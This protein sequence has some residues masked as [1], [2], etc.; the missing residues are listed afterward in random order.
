MTTVAPGLKPAMQRGLIRLG[1]AVVTRWS[2][3]APAGCMNFG[4][5]AL[6]AESA[7]LAANA[8]G[9][10][11][12]GYELYAR[13]A[14]ATD[15][16]DKQALE[17]GCGRGGGAAFLTERFGLARLTGLDFSP[18]VIAVAR[19][20]HVDERLRFVQG[21]AEKLPFAEESFDVVFNVESSHCYPNMGRFAA[22]VFRV[23]RPGG[24][25]LFADLRPAATVAE[26]RESL[27][28]TGLVLLE[29]EN[30]TQNVVR[31]LEL[32]TPR[33]VQFV[34]ENVPR[35]L[36]SQALNFAA[37]TGSEVYRDLS[38][39]KLQYVRYALEKPAS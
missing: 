2:R 19:E 28:G 31:A 27:L 36:Q 25:L 21:D 13:V 6:D 30:I 7:P 32:D 26:M 4:Y 14:G 5:A 34:R 18:R 10:E 3:E 39:G 9:G 22:E 11:T 33:R 8:V 16:K 12:Y 37:T 15:L 29:E 20:R 24:Q 1:Y 17:V 23:L 35:R 38:D